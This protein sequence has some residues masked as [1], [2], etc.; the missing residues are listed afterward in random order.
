MLVAVSDKHRSAHFFANT[1]GFPTPEE[2]GAF[3][4]VTLTDGIVVNFVQAP[5]EAEIL[6]QHY[7]FLVS[8]G[9][10]DDIVERLKRQEIMFWADPRMTQPNATNTNHGGRGVYFKGPDG[11]FLEALTCRYESDVS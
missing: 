1:F 4:A 10:F 6:G 7:A 11:H 2:D 5:P 8:D 9:V 3:L